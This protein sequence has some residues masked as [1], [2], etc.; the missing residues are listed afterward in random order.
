MDEDL[1]RLG[2]LSKLHYV[3]GGLIALFA[4][5][6]L[7]HVAIGLA[8]LLGK[9][10]TSQGGTPPPAIFGLIFLL[11]GILFVLLGWGTAFCIILAGKKL[12]QYKHW[13]FCVAVA[14]V[15]LM[16][17]PLGTLLGVFTIVTLVKD[18]VKQ[19]FEANKSLT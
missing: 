6:P 13:T 1:K 19:M 2:L 12:A 7:A 16:M 14:A 5:I 11:V 17:V 10:P 9:L 18:P 15:Q 4:C 3:M 8:I